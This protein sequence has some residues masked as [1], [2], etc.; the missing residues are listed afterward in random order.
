MCMIL[1]QIHAAQFSVLCLYFFLRFING[2]FRD[3]DLFLLFLV[4]TSVRNCKMV[5][6][7]W[8]LSMLF[9]TGQH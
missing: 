8:L 7:A 5:S 6:R 3:H 1:I 2:L 4:L 9:F